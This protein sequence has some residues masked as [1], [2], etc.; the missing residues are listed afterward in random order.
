MAGKCWC[1]CNQLHCW[2]TSPTSKFPK[3]IEVVWFKPGK[4]GS[5]S[6]HAAHRA[7]LPHL[8]YHLVLTWFSTAKNTFTLCKNFR[9]SWRSPT[10]HICTMM[11]FFS[12]AFWRALERKE[13]ASKLGHQ[14]S[15]QPPPSIFFRIYLSLARIS[16][17]RTLI[18]KA[19]CGVVQIQLRYFFSDG[20]TIV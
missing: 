9:L 15:S 16:N 14:F 19:N 18:K 20:K 12:A 17:T 5:R 8:P 2:F 4:G 3:N 1:R 10:L 13:E 6:K 11:K 7:I